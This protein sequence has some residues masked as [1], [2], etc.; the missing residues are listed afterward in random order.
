MWIIYPATIRREKNSGRRL[1]LGF[2]DM[3]NA[4]DT[5]V[6]ISDTAIYETS[7]ISQ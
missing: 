5:K 4:Y 3:Q 6:L 2:I 7:E 1:A